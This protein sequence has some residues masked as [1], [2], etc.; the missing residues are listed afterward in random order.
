MMLMLMLR[1]MLLQFTIAAYTQYLV[2][3]ILT[4]IFNLQ[5]RTC[6]SQKPKGEYIVHTESKTTITF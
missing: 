3:Q 1:L 4:V 6:Y 2:Y 5:Y